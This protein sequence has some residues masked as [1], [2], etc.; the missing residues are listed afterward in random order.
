MDL[1]ALLGSNV[2]RFWLRET[3]RVLEIVHLCSLLL[4]IIPES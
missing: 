4:E 2:T 3:L 1:F